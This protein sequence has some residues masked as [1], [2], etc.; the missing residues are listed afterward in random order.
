MKNKEYENPSLFGHALQEWCDTF[1]NAYTLH[2]TE[3]VSSILA[4]KLRGESITTH[5][6]PIEPIVTASTINAIENIQ[7]AETLFSLWMISTLD[8]MQG[9]ISINCSI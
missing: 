9:I 2:G 4:K 6:T 3:T 7:K 8:E 1:S 5:M